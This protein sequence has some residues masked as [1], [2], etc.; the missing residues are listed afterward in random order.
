MTQTIHFI[1]IK[2]YYLNIS[3][4][5]QISNINNNKKTN[6][7]IQNFNKWYFNK[8]INELFHTIDLIK[9]S[10]CTTERI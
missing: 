4:K 2:E 9:F 5:R 8:N 10:I 6:Q 3:L 1:F 7:N